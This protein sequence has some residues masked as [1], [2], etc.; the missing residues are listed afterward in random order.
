M[1]GGQSVAALD[2]MTKD[3]LRSNEIEGV[4]LNSDK[5]R[6]SIARYWGIDTAVITLPS[7]APPNKRI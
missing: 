6:L 5:V 3:V 4:I 7:N 2:V 1:M